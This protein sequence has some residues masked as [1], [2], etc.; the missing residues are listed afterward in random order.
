MKKYLFNNGMFNDDDFSN[1][2]INF[3]LENTN[4]EDKKY[5]SNILYSTNRKTEILIFIHLSKL[6]IS[7]YNVSSITEL[8]NIKN[9]LINFIK[10]NN[11][12]KND[13]LIINNNLYTELQEKIYKNYNN[14]YNL[15]NISN[16]INP[17]EY[18]LYLFYKA[19][20]DLDEESIDDM[21]ELTEG[22]KLTDDT[23]DED[24]DVDL[25]F[26]MDD[27]SDSDSDKSISDNIKNIDSE[28]KY[29]IEQNTTDNREQYVKLFSK[30]YNELCKL[31]KDQV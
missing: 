15:Y 6:Q 4:K 9:S 25:D 29:K 21:I 22:L 10:F 18:Y 17:N 26:N 2:D 14:I 5:C 16:K 1:I 20:E 31:E 8:N 24:D 28:M 12:K 27:D 11:I 13:K 30:E 19:L 3:I 7:I 23:D